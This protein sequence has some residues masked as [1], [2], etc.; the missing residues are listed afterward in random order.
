MLMALA[1]TPV[2]A[3]K[4]KGKP[5]ADEFAI[6]DEVNARPDVST[7]SLFGFTGDADT[8]EKGER[9]LSFDIVTRVGKRAVTLDDGT[10]GGKGQFRVSAVRAGFDYGVTDDFDVEASI[11]GDL[12]SVRGVPDLIDKSNGNFNGASVE[13][14]YRLLARTAENPVAIAVSLEPR[15]S[16]IAET[17][18]ISQNAFSLET[19][20]MLDAR[21]IPGLLWYGVH[22]SFEPQAGRFR[23]GQV[24]RESSFSVSNALSMRVLN[25]TYLGVEGSYKRAYAGAFANSLKGEAA[26]F[27]PT[28]LH[29]FSKS[30]SLSLAW[31]TQVWGRQKQPAPLTAHNLDLWNFDRHLVRAKLNVNF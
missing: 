29:N 16:R 8:N 17:E 12:R 6:P 27:G 11:F 25:N 30:T 3:G 14:K 9:Q 5:S 23:S 21:V 19:G 13:F 18:G 7:D 4:V 10:P 1:A 2:W 24:E 26:F 31:S 20:L 15:W 22:I 28:V